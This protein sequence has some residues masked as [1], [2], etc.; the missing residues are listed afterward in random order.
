MNKFNAIAEHI[1]WYLDTL[2]NG[3]PLLIIVSVEDSQR[4]NLVFESFVSSQIIDSDTSN[5]L[6]K[7]LGDIEHCEL[8]SLRHVIEEISGT[9]LSDHADAVGV[10]LEM[11]HL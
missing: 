8:F 3:D 5:L 10:V 2:G 7:H 4:L 6:V 11:L 9:G 1:E